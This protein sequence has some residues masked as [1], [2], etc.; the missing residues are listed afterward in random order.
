MR[1]AGVYKRERETMDAGSL[2]AVL[3]L[4]TLFLVVG[5]VC[6]CVAI[7]HHSRSFS[8]ISTPRALLAD[9]ATNPV[10]EVRPA[11]DR[12]TIDQPTDGPTHRPTDR[13]IDRPTDRS[14]D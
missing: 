5:I 2:T 9:A 11:T 7:A 8:R 14:I 4:A 12:R 13:P 10:R 1:V 6:A 3:S